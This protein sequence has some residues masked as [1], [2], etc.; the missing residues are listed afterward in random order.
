MYTEEYE[1]RSNGIKSFASKMVLV[2]LAII[3]LV[4]LVPKFVAPTKASSKT[5]GEDATSIAVSSLQEQIFA[6]NLEKMKDAA[7][8]YFT[9]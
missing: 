1:N 7:I 8:S 4:W 5:S 3:L 6:N 9:K 2:V